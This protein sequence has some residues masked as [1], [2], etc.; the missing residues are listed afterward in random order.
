MLCQFQV[1]SKVNHTSPLFLKFFSYIGFYRVLL[2]IPVLYTRSLYS[3]VYRSIQASQMALVVKNPLA[4]AGNIKDASS[5]P[6]SRRYPRGGHGNSLQYSC[7]ENPS[8]RIRKRNTK[9]S[10]TGCKQSDTT[11]ATEKEQVNPNLQF[12]S[13]P[14]IFW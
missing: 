12:L 2:E 7:L 10:L 6:G 1:Y 9:R 5:I 13:L 11:E 3:S 8:K 14:L 4:N